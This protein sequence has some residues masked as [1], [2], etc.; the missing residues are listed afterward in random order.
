MPTMNNIGSQFSS[1]DHYIGFKF[2]AKYNLIKSFGPFV[3]Y[4]LTPFRMNNEGEFGYAHLLNLGVSFNL[5][6]I[7]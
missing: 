4:N 1:F 5:F 2:G 3:N 6:R 7:K